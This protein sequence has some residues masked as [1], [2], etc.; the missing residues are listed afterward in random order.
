MI[1]NYLYDIKRYMDDL[2]QIIPVRFAIRNCEG[3][4]MAEYRN[5]DSNNGDDPAAYKELYTQVAASQSP[6]RLAA[7]PG[8]RIWGFPLQMNSELLES[9]VTVTVDSSPNR[10]GTQVVEAPTVDFIHNFLQL[11]T[12]RQ[13]QEKELTAFTAEL[14]MQY[15]YISFIYDIEETIGHVT[16]DQ[17]SLDYILQKARDLID[18][19]LVIMQ[20]PSKKKG[21][22]FHVSEKIPAVLSNKTIV[23]NITTRLIDQLKKGYDYISYAEICTDTDIM[24]YF[25]GYTALLVIPVMFDGSVEGI[26]L[27]GRQQV[28]KEFTIGDKRMI[29]VVSDIVAIV[30][31]NSELFDDLN[32][33][34]FSLMK[35]FVT[36]IEEKDPYTRGHSDRVNNLSL[37]MGKALGIHAKEMKILNY[38]SLL[39]DIGKIG[40]IESIL[41]KPNKLTDK[42]YINIKQHPVKGNKILAHIKQLKECLPGILYHHERIDGT[43]YPQGLHG[44]EI[45]LISRI[46]AVADVY[47]AMTSTRAYRKALSTE[48]TLQ[49]LQQ[50][51]G[52][53]LDPDIVDVFINNLLWE[54]PSDPEQPSAHEVST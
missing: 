18:A 28:G 40:I 4:V 38:A 12:A 36:A 45:P 51:S 14:S 7:K 39:H 54:E 27:F 31:T 1:E 48:T 32:Q 19:D 37:K 24:Q 49:E 5:A 8:K 26:I 35:S 11:V 30:L 42:E 33:F 16:D 6:R 13:E 21:S 29:T 15:E 9:F 44:E 46:I 52:T 17:A 22:A 47:D 41:N 10:S 25:E 2:S 53:Q 50:V 3:M 20:I 43:G 23:K 34:L